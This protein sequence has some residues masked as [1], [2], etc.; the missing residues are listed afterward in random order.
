M[1]GNSEVV[2]TL[3][4][5]IRCTLTICFLSVKI[6]SDYLNSNGDT[7]SDYITHQIVK[8]AIMGNCINIVNGDIWC[9]YMYTE[10]FS[11]S[12]YFKLTMMIPNIH[13]AIL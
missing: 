8:L 5:N 1:L 6:S 13:A 4:C 2:K 3:I 10:T 9:P 11:K 7:L 12:L